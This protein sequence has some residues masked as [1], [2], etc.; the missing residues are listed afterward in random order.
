M[1]TADVARALAQVSND[2]QLSWGGPG[3][4]YFVGRRSLAAAARC[5]VL[6]LAI[7]RAGFSPV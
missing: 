6:C 1:Q 5:W 4:V 7:V 2:N 3:V